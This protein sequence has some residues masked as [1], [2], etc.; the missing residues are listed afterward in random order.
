MAEPPV[1]LQLL[2]DALPASIRPTSFE[3]REAL[4][5]PFTMAVEVST[6]DAAFHV[7]PDPNGRTGRDR[8]GARRRALSGC[9]RGVFFTHTAS[10]S[11]PPAS[12]DLA[13]IATAKTV[14]L[15]GKGRG[16]RGKELIRRRAWTGEWRLEALPPRDRHSSNARATDLYT[17]CSPRGK[18][19]FSCTPRAR[20]RCFADS[21]K[22]WWGRC[23]RVL[24]LSRASPFGSARRSRY[25]PSP[26][27]ACASRY[28]FGTHAKPNA[29]RRRV[30]MAMPTT[31]TRSVTKPQRPARASPLAS[32]VV[33]RGDLASTARSPGVGNRSRS[34][35]STGATQRKFVC[36][37]YVERRKPVTSG[38]RLGN[39]VRSRRLHVL[40]R[41]REAPRIM[42]CRRPRHW[43]D[44]RR[45]D[46]CDKRPREGP[47][48]MGPVASHE[49][50]ADG[51]RRAAPREGDIIRAWMG[52]ASRSSTAPR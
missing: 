21:T 25:R 31:S 18:L 27:P 48:P 22:P 36:M 16:R 43:P 7:G 12:A 10:S 33:T 52:V 4:S 9:A 41:E 14:H 1:H 3:V 35:A 40:R 19:Y 24:S 45:G 46:H 49:N 42:G 30:G 37:D 20:R 6:E 47:L 2:G 34:P 15:P 26:G 11:V 13:A 50:R 8:H 44:R 5:L 29:V 38:R 32:G 51:A 39:N 28:E 17:G 23:A